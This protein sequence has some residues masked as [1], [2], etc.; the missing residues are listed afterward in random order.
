MNEI[1]IALIGLGTLGLFWAIVILIANK[2]FA[3]EENPI[4]EQVISCLPGVNCGACG[5]A[6]C[7]ALGEALVLKNEDVNHCTVVNIENKE[8]ISTLLGKKLKK[9]HTR[10][11]AKLH[12]SGTKD[13][14]QNT[15][16]YCG[17]DTCFA[18]HITSGGSKSCTFGCLGRGDCVKVCIFAALSMGDNGL[19]QVDEQKCTACGKCVKVC[20]RDLFKLVPEDQKVFILC[21]S[22]DPLN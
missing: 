10:Q 14:V 19:P 13:N 11:I 15:A 4:I 6:G 22:H 1:L 3:V 20:P 7:G 9:P 16:L 8:K 21:S 5:F 17:L 12:C 2:F 18:E